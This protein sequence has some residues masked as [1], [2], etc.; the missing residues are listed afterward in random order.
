MVCIKFILV[1]KLNQIL[2]RIFSTI[3]FLPCFSKILQNHFL[4]FRISLSTNYLL[5]YLSNILLKL[6]YSSSSLEKLC[7]LSFKNFFKTKKAKKK[8]E[9][10]A[11]RR[12]S[13]KNVLRRNQ[14]QAPRWRSPSYSSKSI[15]YYFLHFTLDIFKSLW[16]KVRTS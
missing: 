1:R 8:Y 5:S 13:Q 7:F 3:K 2:I 10:E 12:N 4:P 16:L 6:F 14:E 11:T 9:D 15:L